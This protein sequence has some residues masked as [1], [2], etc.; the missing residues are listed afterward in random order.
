MNPA[1]DVAALAQYV[2]REQQTVPSCQH[3]ER[4]VNDGQDRGVRLGVRLA[5]PEDPAPTNQA[6]PHSPAWAGAAPAAVPNGPPCGHYDIRV[7]P[8]QD[9]GS[10]RATARFWDT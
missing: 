10:R 9:H 2:Q 4:I 1:A 6:R 5:E 7:V 8:Q 3:M